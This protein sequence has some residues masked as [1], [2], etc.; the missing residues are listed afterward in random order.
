MVVLTR[1]MGSSS[2]MSIISWMNLRQLAADMCV[3]HIKTHLFAMVVDPTET[4]YEMGALGLVSCGT[5]GPRTEILAS[6]AC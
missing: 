5:Y 3:F 1:A 6:S 2:S 4:T